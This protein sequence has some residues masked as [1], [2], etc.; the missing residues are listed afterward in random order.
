MVLSL[1]ERYFC[2]FPFGHTFQS[3]QPP[4]GPEREWN[5]RE[6]MWPRCRQHVSTVSSYLSESG[7]SF[8]KHCGQWDLVCFGELVTPLQMRLSFPLFWLFA[9][10]DFPLL[11][12][13]PPSVRISPL[14]KER[15]A[16]V[17]L[18]FG[19]AEFWLFSCPSLRFYTSP[20]PSGPGG[21]RVLS[22]GP[23][24]HP[25]HA[26][27]P[28]PCLSFSSSRLQNAHRHLRRA[29]PN[30]RWGAEVTS[31]KTCTF[32]RTNV[33]QLPQG[34]GGGSLPEAPAS[35]R[36]SLAWPLRCWPSQSDALLVL[37]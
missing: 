2:L 5:V 37:Y 34:A 24:P 35:V 1:P 25:P 3:H 28:G 15:T 12:L 36:T 14:V 13:P 8:C 26:G 20:C 4:A 9:F 7:F 32:L 10:E 16:G 23:G 22:S 29:S 18:R 31:H 6:R 30:L 21:G 19:P 17:E 33:M 11:P 27:E